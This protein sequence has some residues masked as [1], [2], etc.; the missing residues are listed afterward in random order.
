M[1]LDKGKQKGTGK[2]TSQN[3]LDLGIPVPTITAAVV[4]EDGLRVDLEVEGVRE[5][6]IHDFGLAGYATGWAGSYPG[7]GLGGRARWEPFALL[8][9]DVFAEHI[10]V[11]ND[12]GLRHDH[13]VGFDL[14]LPIDLGAGL[15]VRPLFGFCAVFSFSA[16]EEED[17]PR[18]DDVLFGIHGGAGVEWAP[19]S[20]WS[21]FLDVQAV[22]YLGHDRTGQGWTGSVEEELTTLGVVQADLGIQLHL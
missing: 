12:G 13:P 16:P 9:V 20:Q 14:Y 4:S 19:L 15:R 22:G 2:W 6:H 10:L 17:G 21:L 3:A 5:G 8:G 11:E 7:V 1:I 18:A